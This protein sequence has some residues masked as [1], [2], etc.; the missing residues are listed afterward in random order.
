MQRGVIDAPDQIGVSQ[1]VKPPAGADLKILEVFVA[2]AGVKRDIRICLK[3]E[4]V[5]VPIGF[6]DN[7]GLYIGDQIVAGVAFARQNIIVIG[8]GH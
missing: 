5:T 3:L 4:R 2:V 8:F 6:H 1:D 7:R